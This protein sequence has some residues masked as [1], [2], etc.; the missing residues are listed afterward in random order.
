M[1]NEASQEGEEAGGGSQPQQQPQRQPPHL[2][3]QQSMPLPS[4]QVQGPESPSPGGGGRRGSAGPHLMMR[5]ASSSGAP[6]A[7]G[8]K[9]GSIVELPAE[10]DLSNLSEEEKAKILSVMA[11]AQSLE[12][13]LPSPNKETEVTRQEPKK[14][15]EHC[16]IC[17][18]SPR[19][20]ACVEC[21]SGVCRK[22]SKPI[23]SGKVS[24]HSLK[25]LICSFSWG[26]NE[27]VLDSLSELHS[28]AFRLCFERDCIN[29][30]AFCVYLSNRIASLFKLFDIY[31]CENGV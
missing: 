22:C 1:G 4:S 6:P 29:F 9:R 8:P 20:S 25:V 11:R 12:E 10:V 13:D 5:R 16:S 17:R 18:A 2:V 23:P 3:T 7:P 19:E 15:Q 28:F 24:F 26:G 27:P 14:E 21:G 31:A 30:C